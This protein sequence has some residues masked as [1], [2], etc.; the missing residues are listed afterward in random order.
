M[1]PAAGAPAGPLPFPH[2]DADT[3]VDLARRLVPGTVVAGRYRI[4]SQVG[5]G[6]M[7]V[8]YKARDQELD[9]DVA[10]KVLRPDMGTDPGW[11]ARFRRELVLAR[12]ITHKNVVRIHDIGESNGLRFLTMRLV[13]GRSLLD[14]LQS[15]GRLEIDRALRIFRQVA[16]ALQQAHDAGIVHRDLKPGNVLLSHDEMA[17]IT[18]FGVARSL[19][20]DRTT[21]AGEIV[22]TLDYLS[23]EQ[24][25]GEDADARSDIYALGLLLFE[26]LTG[27]L[28]FAS[29]SRAETVARHLAGRW[30][31]IADMG[32]P[33]PAHVRRLMRRCLERDPARR[34]PGVRELLVDLDSRPVR[35]RARF[36]R[37]LGFLLVAALAVPVAGSSYQH[38]SAGRDARPAS[39]PAVGVTSVAVLPLGD[40]TGEPSLAWTATGVPEMLSAQ[41]AEAAPLRVVSPA[42]VLR[43]LRD[44]RLS[45]APLEEASLRRVAQMLDVTHLVS[46]SLRRAGS[47]LRLDL[48][49]L[50]VDGA[51]TLAA[52]R[53]A[54]ETQDAGDLFRVIG[55]VGQRLHH[56]LGA[57]TDT[58]AL[59]PEP[60]TSSLEAANAYREGRERLL[61]GNSVQAAPAFERALAA[62]PRF[63]S[64]LVG[65]GEAY[66]ALGYHD[67]AVSAIERAADVLGPPQ[68]RLAWRVRAR[69][70]MLRGDPAEAESV[71]A[72]LVRRYPNDTEALFDL[73]AAQSARGAA[74]KTVETLER[75]TSLDKTDARAWYLLGRNMIQAG[76]ARRAIS[77]P[78][79]QALTLMTQ[80]GNEQGQ[81]DVLN[82]R[83]VAHQRL[84]EYAAAIARYGEAAEIRKRI[85]DRRGTAV[86]LK[87]RASVRI[88]TGDFAPAE[89]DLR[90]AR[91]IY[92]AIGDRKG[93]AD[94]ATDL[95]AL[96]E[97]RGEYPQARRAY[98][99]ALRIRRELGDEQQLAQSYDN[100]G[101][102]FFLEGEHDG[103]LAYWR[104]ALE[105]REKNGDK[106][107]LVHSLQ[108][109]GFLQTAQ[110][111][112]SEAMKSFLDALERARD[113]DSARALA[114]SHG[115]LGLLHQYE[116]RYAGAFAAYAE[117]LK[118]LTT[119][120][121]KRG[122]AEFTI[123]EAGALLELGRLEEAGTKLDAAEAWVGEVRNQEQTADY[124]AARGEW[125]LARGEGVAA[126]RAFGQAEELA[127]ASGSPAAVLRAQVSRGAALAVL[128]DAAAAPELA[129]AERRAD[130]LGDVILRLRASEALARAELARGRRAAAE[131]AAQRAL[132]LAQ[133]SG[134]EAGL[135]RLHALW[136]RIQQ[137]KGDAA[138][139]D[140][141]FAES[142]RRIEPL[143]RGLTPEM[144][145]SFDALP[146]VREV[147][148]P[149]IARPAMAAR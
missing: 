136:G 49:L 105:L 43:T 106:R 145:S 122:L 146:A 108:N 38:W 44:L 109:M 96:H 112:W 62:D 9:Q 137:K 73:G 57:P 67:K 65:L 46:G 37:P 100:V 132:D 39:P 142:A 10:L 51:G 59:L 35:I 87:N 147:E 117:A 98:Q 76:D 144:R 111:R 45:G 121:D 33:V 34:Y 123:K 56:D 40:E 20:G 60:G 52:R 63:A 130:A 83:G 80:I 32:V 120:Q 61:A 92:A 140:A 24:I 97:G 42:R 1:K 115:N 79:L 125:H 64:A 81:A 93:L 58:S 94:V 69:L 116:G 119:L 138:A 74:A 15:E 72:E 149:G 36:A 78:L 50:T 90:A 26:M 11:V 103:A 30:R 54:A 88:L 6:G 8:V 17:Y 99:Q 16:E 101:Y 91:E 133:R 4:A 85:G 55:E 129:A 14:L 84:G 118:V 19:R 143:R 23:P 12:E 148:G 53:L 25:A 31:D 66:Q 48:Q 29:A 5:R 21:R 134:W 89:P 75:L 68:T 41:L 22:G 113:I 2:R 27:E 70:A 71:Y 18:D 135:W 82:A 28:P 102:V 131:D 114:V 13:E 141:A 128:G 95:G 110:G 47:T 3:S 86:S 7:G 127:R 77:G 124:Y 107:G 126:R 139:A 104:Q